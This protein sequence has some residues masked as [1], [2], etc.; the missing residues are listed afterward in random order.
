MKKQLISAITA[1]GAAVAAL[2]V[3]AGPAQAAS[4]PPECQAD[5]G[6]ACVAVTNGAGG[7]VHSISVNGQCATFTTDS[8]NMY[9]P[10]VTVDPSQASPT[11]LTYSGYYCESSTQ[12]SQVVAWTTGSTGTGNYRWVTI[13]R[14]W[15]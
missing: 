14:V 4:T 1:G 7:Q 12:N 15:M 2:A 6:S 8:R 9:F 3:T 10:D 11:T 13:G 5:A